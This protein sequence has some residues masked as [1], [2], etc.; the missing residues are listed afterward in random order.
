MIKYAQSSI[1]RGKEVISVTECENYC[2]IS[3]NKTIIKQCDCL[4]SHI[5]VE[6]F[7]VKINCKRKWSK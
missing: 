7:K 6:D 1:I 3:D 5:N 2:L 4:G